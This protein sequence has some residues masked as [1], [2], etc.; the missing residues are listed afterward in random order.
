MAKLREEAEPRLRA[1]RDAERNV[2]PAPTQPPPPPRSPEQIA[3]EL[4]D[5]HIAQEGCEFYLRSTSVGMKSDI[6]GALR[7]MQDEIDKLR[8]RATNAEHVAET[9]QQAAIL[10]V[11]EVEA[12]FDAL[13]TR[14]ERAERELHISV[15]RAEKAEA[16]I[17]RHRDQRGDDRC[18][19]D[20]EVL[21]KALPEGY[22]PPLRDSAVELKNCQRFIDCRNNP[23]TT[24]IS[25]ERMIEDL[26][27]RANRAEKALRDANRGAERN[28]WVSVDLAKK[29]NQA[30]RERDEALEGLKPFAEMQ[31]D[32]AYATLKHTVPAHTQV[33]IEKILG[34]C[35]RSAEIIA[36][37][38]KKSTETKA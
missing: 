4:F 26:R 20:D 35:R 31:M 14:A 8:T 36:K 10:R 16:A 17:R 2:E 22:T 15:E 37:H 30:E 18:W 7:K 33:E 27:S 21:Y 11:Q 1:L 9:A 23:A 24:Y 29:L 3:A 38:E 6:A 28:A 5:W 13:R 12:G 25:P 32:E 19:M 34:H